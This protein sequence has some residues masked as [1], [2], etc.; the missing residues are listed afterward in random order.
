MYIN[1]FSKKH[2][3]F[4]ALLFD[5]TNKYLAWLN[6][7]EAAKGAFWKQIE[8]FNLTQLS[9]VQIRYNTPMLWASF[10]FW[11]KTTNNLHFRYGMASPSLSDLVIMTGPIGEL[12]NPSVLLLESTYD[13]FTYNKFIES[14]FDSSTIEVF[15]SKYVA[16]P[17][18]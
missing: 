18:F 8:I 14:N 2:R 13:G 10:Y 17:T 3:L 16:F 11:N 6:K 7:V 1:Y 4:S 15:A 12:L 9:R 5:P